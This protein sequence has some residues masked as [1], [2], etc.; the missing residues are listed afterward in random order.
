MNGVDPGCGYFDCC[1][2][3]RRREATHFRCV[4]L[5]ERGAFA[6]ADLPGKPDRAWFEQCATDHQ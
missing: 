4:G 2:G 3:R 6:L 5:Y 1:W